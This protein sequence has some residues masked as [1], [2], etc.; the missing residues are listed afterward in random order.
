MLFRSPSNSTGFKSSYPVPAWLRDGHPVLNPVEFDGIKTDVVKLLP[1]AKKL[2]RVA[3][4]HS[5]A[6][7][8]KIMLRI[9]HIKNAGNQIFNFIHTLRTH[10]TH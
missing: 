8:H 1:Y 2:Q 6:N 3:I 10:T 9:H 4:T 7:D 5:I